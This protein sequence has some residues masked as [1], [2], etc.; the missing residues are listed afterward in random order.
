MD[1]IAVVKAAEHMNDCVR[2]A[3]IG[4]KLVSEPFAVARALDKTGYIDNLH[5]SGNN[6]AFGVTEFAQTVQTL[7]GNS[8][9]AEVRLDRTERKIGRLRF[10]VAQTVEQG[11]FAHIGQSDYTALKRHIQLKIDS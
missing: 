1:H 5:R 8:D 6:A 4:K 9:H 2:L 10:G 7:V 11:G 3:N